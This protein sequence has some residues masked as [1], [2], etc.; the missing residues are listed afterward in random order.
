MGVSMSIIKLYTTNGG[1]GRTTSAAAL[2]LGFLL[3]TSSMQ[4][5]TNRG[6]NYD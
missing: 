3:S 6:S 1:I 2:K 4:R 5:T